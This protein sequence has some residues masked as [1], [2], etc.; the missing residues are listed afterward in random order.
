MLIVSSLFIF[1]A[2][3]DAVQP[4]SYSYVFAIGIDKGKAKRYNYSLMVQTVGEKNDSSMVGSSEIFSAEGDTLFE[5]VDIIHSVVSGEMNFMRTS[6]IIFGSEVAKSGGAEDF[7]KV[8]FNSLRMRQSVKLLVA[9]GEALDFM[10]NL[11][12]QYSQNLTRLQVDLVMDNKMGILPIT[13]FSIM[14]ENV[15]GGRLDPVLTLCNVAHGAK[16]GEDNAQNTS[17]VLRTGGMDSYVMGSALFDGWYMKG[18][19]DENDTMYLLMARGQFEKGYMTYETKD[20]KLATLLI[21]KNADIKK[22]VDIKNKNVNLKVSLYCTVEFD[23]TSSIREKWEENYKKEVE[24]KIRLQ[25]ERIAALVMEL[26]CDSLG[27]GR[28]VSTKFYN[29]DAWEKYDFQKHYKE[30]KTNFDVEV[31][32]KD[33][34]IITHMD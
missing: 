18:T 28:L 9:Q 31:E 10:K 3:L 34:N 12:S 24:E 15:M 32:L 14:S 16:E 17:G 6:V 13:S 19:I 4:E 5:A 11:G 21:E 23:E 33:K 20:K 2:C 7:S 27:I 1:T 25:L 30:F 29:T 8:S 26:N 22:K